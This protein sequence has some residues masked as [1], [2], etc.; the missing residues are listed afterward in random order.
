[1]YLIRFPS[2]PWQHLTLLLPPPVP[3][4]A[5]LLRLRLLLPGLALHLSGQR[6]V[7]KLGPA[8]RRPAA[9]LLHCH[10]FYSAIAVWHANGPH[11][12]SSRYLANAQNL[13]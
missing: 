3:S 5:S 4:S 10:F 12:A 7:V 9:A 6:G 11:L 13:R 1:M 8:L 2:V